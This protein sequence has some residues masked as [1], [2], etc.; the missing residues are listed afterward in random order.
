M[1]LGDKA[2]G[3]GAGRGAGIG[4][5][6]GHHQENGVENM[7]LFEVVKLGKSATQVCTCKLDGEIMSSFLLLSM[8]IMFPF[9]VCCWWLDWGLQTGP[10]HC[11]LGLNQLLY[12]VLWLQ[13]YI[14][15]QLNMSLKFDAMKTWENIASAVWLNYLIF[16]HRRRE[17]RDV[18]AYAKLWN[19]PKNDRGVWWGTGCIFILF[20]YEKGCI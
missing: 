7:T 2:K 19:N 5:V 14:S 12:P 8:T 1:A 10:G 20:P 3:G 9:S 16:Q 13:R 11:T 18:P 15:E 4:R 17:W 6:N